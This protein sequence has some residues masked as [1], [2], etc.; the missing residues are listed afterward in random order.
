MVNT[1]ESVPTEAKQNDQEKDND[2][3][4]HMPERSSK[5]INNTTQELSERLKTLQSRI[6]AVRLDFKKQVEGLRMRMEHVN[7]NLKTVQGDMRVDPN[8]AAT[9]FDESEDEERKI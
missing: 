7:K 1:K 6:D 4:D 8:N 9:A 3:K 5:E 2:K